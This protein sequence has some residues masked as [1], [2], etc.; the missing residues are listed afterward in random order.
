MTDNK[1]QLLKE[2]LRNF[3]TLKGIVISDSN[4]N[5]VVPLYFAFS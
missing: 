2:Y 5:G 3:T 4:I 1:T